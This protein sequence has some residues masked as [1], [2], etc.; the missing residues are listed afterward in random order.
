[1]VEEVAGAALVVPLAASAA[2]GPAR[3]RPIGCYVAAP[4]LVSRYRE[5]R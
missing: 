3:C 4:H 5:D 2:G 1:M